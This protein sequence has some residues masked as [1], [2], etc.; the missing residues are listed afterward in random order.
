M[1]SVPSFTLPSFTLPTLAVVLAVP[2]LSTMSVTSVSTVS[3][4]S[5]MSVVSSMSGRWL[6]KPL[7]GTCRRDLAVR[8]AWDHRAWTEPTNPGRNRAELWTE[9]TNNAG[10]LANLSEGVG[11]GAGLWGRIERALATRGLCV[12]TRRHAIVG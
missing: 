6:P 3:T 4:V 1:A 7:A 11:E 8:R 2:A 5:M 9:P 12:R 10:I